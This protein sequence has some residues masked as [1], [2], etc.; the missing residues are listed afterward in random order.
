MRSLLKIS[1]LTKEEIFRIFEITDHIEEY[2][3]F[4]KGKRFVTFF[5]RH[6]YQNLDHF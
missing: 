5:S 6:Q 2:R 3:D 4:M 1:D